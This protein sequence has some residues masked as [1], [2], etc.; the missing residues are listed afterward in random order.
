MFTVHLS[1]K[2]YISIDS[3]ETDFENTSPLLGIKE[4]CMVVRENSLFLGV[5]EKITRFLE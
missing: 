1:T 3:S 5:L 2:L 4:V